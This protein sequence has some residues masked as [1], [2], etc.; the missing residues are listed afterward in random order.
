[1]PDLFAGRHALPVILQSERAECGLACLAMIASFHGRRMDLNTMRQR[2]AISA[3]GATLGD[4]QAIAR[5]LSLQTR[6]LRLEMADLRSLQLPAI[7]HWDMNHFVVLKAVRGR[8]LWLHDPATGLRCYTLAEAAAHFTGVALECLPLAGFERA[9]EVRRSR[10]G[11]L[12]VRDAGF[13][14]ALLQLLLLSAALQAAS[15]GSA[16]YLQL[17]IDEGVVRANTDMLTVL[18]LGFGLLALVSVGMRWV[19]G[20]LQLHFSNQLGF[21]MAGNLLHHLMRLPADYFARRH[22]GDLVS[23]FGAIREI[24]QVL[25]EELLTAVLDGLF[26]LAAL[27]AMLWFNAGL[28]LLVLLFV[29]L[30]ALLRLA[31][32]PLLRQLSEQ[33]IAAEARTSTELMESMRAMEIIKFY[34]AEL[35]RIHSW[36]NHHAL[37]INAQVQLSRVLV[38]VEAAYGVLHGLEHALVVYLAASAVLTGALTLGFVTAFIAL[39]THFAGAIRAF[40][41]K[42]VQ[43][44]LLRL[45][46]ERISDITCAEPEFGSLHL[47]A[48]RLSGP[49]TLQ[50]QQV[51][52]TYPG[53]RAPVF[54]G[55]DLA[56]GAGEIVA[57]TGAS[58]C[59]KSTL[60]RL[61]AGLLQPDSGLR[62]VD[63]ETQQQAD[64]LRRFRDSCAGVLQGE[65][66]LSGTLLENVG[67]FADE[68]DHTRLQQA[69][70]MARIDGFIAALPMGW[71]S[72]V[73]DM[74]SIMSAG[75]GQ[76]LLLARAFYKQP[77]ILFLD[78][79]TANLDPDV[80]REILEEIKALGVTTVL[81]THREA[82]LRVATRI[83]HLAGGHLHEV[84]CAPA[85]SAA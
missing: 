57:I 14:P 42:L 12:F 2:Y 8:E 70:R 19:R 73:G 9:D 53:L 15:I 54:T 60:I 21:Q 55:L 29:T 18:A 45:Q 76:R 6:A 49:A 43:M 11:E 17:V 46:L 41:D 37:Q 74:G 33:R 27:A 65:Q 51:S 72:L 35:A 44:R 62:L 75:Q 81:V 78:E 10:L 5:D 16:F 47:P 58:G 71:N 13:A 77:R 28:A 32:T 36:R 83:V 66:L 3:R 85:Q 24:R 63:G 31:V 39:K 64:A 84:P 48:L 80:E 30:E 23:R 59:G 38:R 52:Y 56:L 1:M 26:A 22:T 4:L 20:M 67:M 68:V 69:A 50:L 79:A 40:I 25:S 61:L 34:C 82:P 7:L